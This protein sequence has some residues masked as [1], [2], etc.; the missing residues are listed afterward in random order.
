[1]W[2]LFALLF[3]LLLYG[4]PPTS[5]VLFIVNLIRYLSAKKVSKAEPD[6]Q[7]DDWLRRIR[8]R[9]VVYFVLSAVSVY[10]SVS[11]TVMMTRD[12]MVYM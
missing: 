8:R 4:I 11:F 5:V 6:I 9:L 10:F 1:M 12:A 7:F 2:R 3:F